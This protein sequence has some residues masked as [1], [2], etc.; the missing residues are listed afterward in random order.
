[1]FKNLL[2]KIAQNKGH[3]KNKIGYFQE[4]LALDPLNAN[5]HLQYAIHATKINR[6]YL[7]FAEFKTAEYLGALNTAVKL[8]QEKIL[9]VIPDHKVMNHNQYYRLKSLSD[10]LYKRSGSTHFSVLD[11]GG[12]EGQLASFIPEVSYCLAE[13]SINSISGTNLPFPNSAFDYVVSCHVLEHIPIDQRTIFLDQLLSK[14]RKGLILLNPF[15]IE[16][17]HV[18]ERLKLIID[19]TSAGWAKEHLECSL[20]TIQFIETYAQD[21]KLEISIKPNGTLTTT[22]SFVFMDYFADR[23]DKKSEIGKINKLF[24]TQLTNILD[25][26]EFPTGYMA[27]IGKSNP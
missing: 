14:S 16:G 26:K 12:G 4:K 20:P 6:P 21:R 24:N 25:S 13:P 7:A 22:L 9:S 3:R 5:L 10:E 23:S 19:I 15:H 17:T 2:K 1:M 27:Y 11:V 18:E 8:Q